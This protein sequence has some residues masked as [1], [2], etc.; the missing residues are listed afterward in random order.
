M[1]MYTVDV[2]RS[3]VYTNNTKSIHKSVLIGVTS[4][5]YPANDEAILLYGTHD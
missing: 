1:V 5:Y 4:I 2:P 3:V